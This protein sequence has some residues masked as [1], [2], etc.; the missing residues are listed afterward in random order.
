MRKHQTP[1]QLHMQGGI[2]ADRYSLSPLI[3]VADL[4]RRTLACAAALV[5][6]EI[7]R[8][9]LW[10]VVTEVTYVFLCESLSGN[11]YKC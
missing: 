9:R 2:S 6:L 5:A 4:L 8:D 1:F 7:N 10:E 11:D 3:D